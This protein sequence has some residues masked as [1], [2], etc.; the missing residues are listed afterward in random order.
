MLIDKG[1]ER[2]ENGLIAVPLQL[3]PLGGRLDQEVSHQ[4]LPIVARGGGTVQRGRGYLESEAEST[5]KTVGISHY[6]CARWAWLQ[7]GDSL[8]SANVRLVPELVVIFCHLDLVGGDLG[9]F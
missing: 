9:R 6:E 1:G 4:L 2:G 5:G 7:H 3:D 8:L